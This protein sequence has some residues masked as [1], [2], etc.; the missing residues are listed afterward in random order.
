MAYQPKHAFTA[1]CKVSYKNVSG[2]LS[3]GYTGERTTTDI[4]DIM[5]AYSLLD[6]SLQYDFKIF[7]NNFTVS[8]DFNNLFNTDYQNVLFYAMPGINFAIALQWKF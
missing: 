3:Y 4:Y 5:S 8:G 1:N 6:L 2:E 7:N